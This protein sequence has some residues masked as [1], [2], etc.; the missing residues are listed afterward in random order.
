MD[1]GVLFQYFEWNLPDDGQ[2]WKK[3]AAEAKEIKANGFTAVWLPPPYKGAQGSKDVGYAVYDM[4]DLG[5]FDQKGSVRTKYGTKDEL[6]AAINACHEAGLQVYVDTVFNHRIGGDAIEEVEI[7]EVN[8]GDRTKHDSDTYKI[9]AY[10]AYTFPGRAGKYSKFQYHA[11]HFNAFGYDDNQKDAKK[12]YRNVAKK[13]SDEVDTEMGNFDYL[14]GADVDLY[15]NDVR[16]DVFAWGKWMLDEF[17]I[18][19]FRLDAVKHMPVSFTRD[20]LGDMSKHAGRELFAVSEYWVPQLEGLQKFIDG[21]EGKTRLFDAPLHYRFVEAAGKG[22]DFDLRQ[23]FDGTLVQANPLMAVTFVENHDSQP[24]Q[25]LQSP[26]TDWFKEL[27]YALILLRKDGYP[28]IFYGDYHG[29]DTTEHKL[30]CFMTSICKLLDARQRFLFGDQHEYFDHPN[31]IGWVLSGDAEHPGSMAVLMS[32]GDAGTKKM[33]TFQGKKT[34][35]DQM[36]NVKEEITTDDNGEAEFKCAA[37][38]LSVWLPK[39]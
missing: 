13:F 1:R 2:L 10:C 17:K 15:D 14:M 26:V 16:A 20:W 5:E 31:C 33:K 18:D 37:G 11:Q 39:N 23:I 25:A 6:V 28:T 4:W 30:T 32:N 8:Q 36:G 29:S 9:K 22:K 27:A 34:Y 3:L 35:R 12:I 7:Q 38:K 21:T 24:G 19:G